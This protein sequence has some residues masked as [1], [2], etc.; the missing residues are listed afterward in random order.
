VL[1]GGRSL[2][3]PHLFDQASA[4]QRLACVRCLVLHPSIHF[5]CP[6]QLLAIGKRTAHPLT[7]H[8]RIFALKRE[9]VSQE[10]FNALVYRCP[11]D[12]G[13]ERG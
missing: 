13:P 12:A 11:Q 8:V 2:A 7:D 3:Q 6:E 10:G 5:L 9:D 1:G 4:E